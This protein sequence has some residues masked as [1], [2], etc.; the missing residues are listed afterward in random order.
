MGFKN[1]LVLVHGVGHTDEGSTIEALL[2]GEGNG[3]V[4]ARYS[5]LQIGEHRYTTATTDQDVD[6]FESN[7][8]QTRPLQSGGPKILLEALLLVLGMLQVSQF[9]KLEPNERRSFFLG[10]LYKGIFLG[11][12]FWCLHPPIVS[13]FVVAEQPFL[14]GT[15]LVALGL[16]V[17]WFQRFDKDLRWGAAWLGA[18]LLLWLTHLFA[19]LSEEQYVLLSTRPYAIFTGLTVLAALLTLAGIRL[20]L[21]FKSRRGRD[22]R[23][24]FVYVPFFVAS[25]VGAV[26]WVIALSMARAFADD[27]AYFLGSW[28]NYYALGLQYSIH[29]AEM[30]SGLLTFICG[31]LLLLP[32]LTYLRAKKIAPAES[33]EKARRTFEIALR[34]IPIL[35]LFSFPIFIVLVI[36]PGPD[37][38]ETATSVWEAYT[39]WSARVLGFLPFLFGGV[40]VALKATG[41]VLYYLS[42]NTELISVR[43]RAVTKLR[44]LV[45][46][47]LGDGYQVL[48]LSHSQGTIIALDVLAQLPEKLG[49][50]IS[51]SP[52]DSLYIDYLEVDRLTGLRAKHDEFKNYYRQD[53]VIAG[54]VRSSENTDINRA[55]TEG[56]HTNYWKEFD[57]IKVRDTISSLAERTTRASSA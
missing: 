22:V 23:Y 5:T 43:D 47:L 12:L 57:L 2:E 48:I 30:Y 8:S 42:P 17:W 56:G 35:L 33:A 27:G 38:N 29:R 55:W 34:I 51:G 31:A 16:A 26:V 37:P 15:W 45:E 28:P 50:W 3:A 24:A 9:Q 40:A 11:G 20:Q 52:S 1:A 41:D 13:M 53:D 4:V 21:D 7:W 44:V 54:Q 32:L 36:L 18:T 25:C 19:P 46:H 39:T 10:R 14:A 49:I 6:I